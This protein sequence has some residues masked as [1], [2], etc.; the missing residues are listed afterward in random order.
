[1]S[2]PP[3]PENH[4]DDLQARCDLA[5]E[6]VDDLRRHHVLYD[7]DD[8][9]GEFFHFFTPTIDDELFFEVVCRRGGYRRYGE[10]NSPVRVAAAGRRRLRSLS[11]EAC[12]P[13]DRA[14]CRR[15]S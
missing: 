9:G 8:T 3:I 1:M 13:A 10:V 5:P 15:T 7:A 2:A 14:H 4:H 11:Y 12:D 6:V